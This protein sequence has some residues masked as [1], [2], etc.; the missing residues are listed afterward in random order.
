M[1]K[2]GRRSA[3]GM[4]GQEADPATLFRL[5]ID[6]GRYP[7]ATNL[8]LEYLESFASMRSSEILQRK[9]MCAVWFPYVSIERLWCQ[10]EDMQKSGRLVDQCGKLKGLLK[11]ALVEHLKQMKL[12][13]DD[14]LASA[15]V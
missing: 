13:S 11:G 3:S 15:L 14:A 1:F 8:L 6:Y 7:E 5:Y 4:A 10:L 2:G 12:D 9:R